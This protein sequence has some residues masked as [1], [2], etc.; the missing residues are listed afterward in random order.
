MKIDSERMAE[1]NLNCRSSRAPGRASCPGRESIVVIDKIGW[2]SDKGCVH[3]AILLGKGVIKG[4]QPCL[5]G[6][7]EEMWSWRMT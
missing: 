4:D 1:R 7:I 3:F 6:E 2:L 5:Q